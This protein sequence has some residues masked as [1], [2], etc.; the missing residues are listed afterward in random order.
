[1]ASATVR[2]DM[3]ETQ[4]LQHLNLWAG[5]PLP[6]N[7]S[8]WHQ[9]LLSLRLAGARA[10]VQSAVKQLQASH[11]AMVLDTDIAQT[12]WCGLRDHQNPFFSPADPRPLWRLAVPCTTPP[13]PPPNNPE[14]TTSSTLI[15]WGGAQRWWRTHAPATEIRALARQ[16]KGHATL[17]RCSNDALRVD[18][19]TPLEPPVAQIHHAL[20]KSFDPNALFNPGRMYS[21][22]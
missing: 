8:A 19:F 2:I 6:L 11:G 15:E 21:G 13:L 7:A 17:F 5:T 4:A 9:N 10:A 1:V 12:F 16:A 22:L 18:V 3:P 14:G 20:K